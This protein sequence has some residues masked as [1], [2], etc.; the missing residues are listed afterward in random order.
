MLIQRDAITFLCSPNKGLCNDWL[1]RSHQF[2]ALTKGYA[3]KILAQLQGN[4][5]LVPVKILVQAKPKDPPTNAMPELLETL[6][7]SVS[8][9]RKPLNT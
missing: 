4:D 9:L 6:S 2:R 1:Y 7:S 5:A 3:A 8:V